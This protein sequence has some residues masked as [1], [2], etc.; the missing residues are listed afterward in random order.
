MRVGTPPGVG[1][2]ILNKPVLSYGA[3]GAG[4]GLPAASTD[5]VA[6]PMPNASHPMDAACSTF[7]MRADRASDA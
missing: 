3:A 1:Y 5:N 7:G 6:C 2:I 4:S